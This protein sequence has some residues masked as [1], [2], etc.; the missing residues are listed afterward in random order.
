M[1]CANSSSAS[2]ANVPSALEGAVG[3]HS[4]SQ[5]GALLVCDP[6][7]SDAL[8]RDH[9]LLIEWGK[10]NAEEIFKRK[11]VTKKRGFFIVTAVHRTKRCHLKCW[12]R[13]SRKLTSK[14][15]VDTSPIPAGS[16]IVDTSATT[17]S[18]ATSWISWEADAE[19]VIWLLT[20]ALF[21]RICGT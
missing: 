12:L 21:L 1:L 20:S 11:E 16:A 17:S 19:K 9:A 4:M 6:I 13:R 15:G 5:G 2:F 18:A 10:A 8:D 7:T 14:V 3:F